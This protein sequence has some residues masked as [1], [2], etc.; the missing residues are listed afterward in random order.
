[1]TWV[2]VCG[3]TRREDVDVAVA[4]GADAVG[5]ITWPGSPRCVTPER[6]AGLGRD[7]GATRI[8]VTVDQPPEALLAAAGAAEVDGVQPG[9]DHAAEAAAAARAAGYLVLRP[10][11]VGAGPPDLGAVPAEEIPLLD[12]A[13]GGMHGGT[14]VAFDWSVAAGLDRDF[15][16]AGGLGPH[17]VADA[18]ARV[19][20]W[21]VDASSRLEREPGVKD[22][23]LV[24][25]FVEEAK[26][27]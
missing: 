25:R 3:M 8:L 22:H 12:T 5:F 23:D 10:I 15:V 6:A 26:R 2:K 19:R 7:A 14:G 27:A 4:A 1:M 13:R 21:G 24:A 17:N 11:P 20:P 9:G 16:L 18:V